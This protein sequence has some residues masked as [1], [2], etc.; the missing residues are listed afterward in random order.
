VPVHQHQQ[1]SPSTVKAK[2]ERGTAADPVQER[3]RGNRERALARRQAKMAASAGRSSST[4]EPKA[5]VVGSF[6]MAS[7]ASV[8][9]G[10]CETNVFGTKE[11]A[12]NSDSKGNIDSSNGRQRSGF[13]A[14][15]FAMSFH[16]REA[17]EATFGFSTLRPFQKRVLGALQSGKDCLVLAGTGSG[18][19]LC[20]QFAAAVDAKALVIVASPLISL[21]RDQVMSLLRKGIS[22]TFLGSAQ[23]DKTMEA[24][25]MNGEFRVVYVCPE[26]LSRLSPALV[27]LHQTKGIDLI[28]VDE[29]H[30]V[31]KWGHDFRPSYRAIG[32]IINDIRRSVRYS[33]TFV[34]CPGRGSDCVA[35]VILHGLHFTVLLCIILLWAKPSILLFASHCFYSRVNFMSY[36][37]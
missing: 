35:L 13:P 23:N 2:P 34:R 24:R 22:A 33:V 36:C 9:G 12:P 10:F 1:S 25:A 26:T 37:G 18:K 20:F 15:A 6:L 8:N 7:E 11:E 31:S 28:A 29:A 32:G 27:R 3:I 17:L 14:P 19:S 30:C 4:V 16:Q 5:A 21:M